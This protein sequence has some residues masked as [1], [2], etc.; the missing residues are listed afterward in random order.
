[1][2]Q[3]QHTLEVG[4]GELGEGG[5]L[6]NLSQ[7][8]IEY[9]LIAPFMLFIQMQSSGARDHVQTSDCLSKILSASAALNSRVALTR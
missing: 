2:C 3:K 4:E 8:M 7:W 6:V 5:H 9:I 1:M